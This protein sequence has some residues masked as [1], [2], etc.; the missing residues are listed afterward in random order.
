M[1]ASLHYKSLQLNHLHLSI[2]VFSAYDKEGK[3]KPV[4]V[5]ARAYIYFMQNLEVHDLVSS[6]NENNS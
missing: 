4:S 6:R 3:R 5:Y 1:R 2:I